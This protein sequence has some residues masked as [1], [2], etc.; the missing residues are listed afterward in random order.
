LAEGK[1]KKEM[2]EKYQSKMVTDYMN[3]LKQSEGAA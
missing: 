2:N 3:Q 1:L